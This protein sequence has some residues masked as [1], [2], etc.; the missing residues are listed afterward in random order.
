MGNIFTSFFSRRQE[1]SPDQALEILY[2]TLTGQTPDPVGGDGLCRNGSPECQ[3]GPAPLV[4]PG[5]TGLRASSPLVMPD[6]T[7]LRASSPLVMPG[8][9]GHL[10]FKEWCRR[11]GLPRQ[12]LDRY[13]RKELGCS[14]QEWVAI[15]Q[16]KDAY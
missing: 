10:S 6:S 4:M 3:A 7:G 2:D 8:L 1:M 15:V 9:T 13:L 14:G 12:K 16:N 5:S 11:L